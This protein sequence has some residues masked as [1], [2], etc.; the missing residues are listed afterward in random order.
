MAEVRVG[1]LT[2]DVTAQGPDDG[3]LVV[4]LH[5]FP[6]SAYEWRAQLAALSAEGYRAVAVDQRGYSPGARP[7]SVEQ[8]RMP[9]LVADVLAVADDM[10]GHTFHLVGHDWGAAVAWQVAGRYPERVRSLTAVSVP[11]PKALTEAMQA[12][13]GDQAAR[14]SY[15]TW[16]RNDSGAVERDLLADNAAR[17]RE[18]YGDLD[19]DEYVHRLQQPGALTAA[20]NWYRAARAEDLLDLPAATVPTLFVWSDADPAIGRAAAEGCARYVEGEFRFEVFEGVDHWI[21]E[22]AADRLNALL[23]DH[24]ARHR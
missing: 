23:L 6:Q 1:E 14:S 8:Y 19:A 15:M 9:H 21:P 13:D 12:A 16:F 17:L 20:L 11:H 5:G 2:F 7:E 10:G 4:F 3:P 22:R 18:V 24:L